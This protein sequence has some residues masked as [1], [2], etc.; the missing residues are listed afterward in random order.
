M[1]LY[2]PKPVIFAHRG[3]SAYAPE[4]TIAAFDLAF[5]QG[6]DGIELDTHLSADGQVVVFHDRTVDRITGVEGRIRD[7]T[8]AALKDLDA[9]SF[10]DS[11]YQG[12]KI[13]TLAEVFEAVGNKIFINIELVGGSLLENLPDKVAE[14][15]K[16]HNMYGKVLFSSFNPL[17]LFRI[18]RLL[19]DEPAGLLAFPKWGG[20][21]IRSHLSRLVPHQTLHPEHGDVTPALVEWVHRSR[22]RVHVYT[23]NDA[24]TLLKMIEWKVD[25]IITDDP[26]L[27]MRIRA[28][29]AASAL[30]RSE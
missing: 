6:A 4:N 15:V 17:M 30:R 19:P 5:E 20:A 26:P 29:M 18:K 25:G 7:L 11:K 22:R 16:R 1:L 13:P 9:G 10:F 2:L 14:L 12:E 24:Q 28:G 8:L 21:L 23:V 3:A 27:A